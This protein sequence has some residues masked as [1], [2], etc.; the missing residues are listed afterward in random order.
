MI[1]AAPRAGV[2]VLA[3]AA[4]LSALSGM[5][6]VVGRSA[7]EEFA[8]FDGRATFIVDKVGCRPPDRI[9]AK[10]VFQLVSRRYVLSAVG[11]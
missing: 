3:D 5:C 6:G 11:T 2:R 1:P 9:E 10:L 8:A 4:A 7:G